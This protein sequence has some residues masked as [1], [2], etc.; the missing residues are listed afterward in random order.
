MFSFLKFYNFILLFNIFSLNLYKFL[1]IF[2]YKIKLIIFIKIF[3][4]N[5]IKKHNYALI[6]FNAWSFGYYSFFFFFDIKFFIKLLEEK[7]KINNYFN[8]YFDLLEKK[9]AKPSY[10]FLL[11]YVS[12]SYNIIKLNTIK[13]NIKAINTNYNLFNNKRNIYLDYFIIENN[14]SIFNDYFFY[15]VQIKFNKI[16]LF[17]IFIFRLSNYLTKEYKQYMGYFNMVHWVP[18]DPDLND[19]TKVKL[20]QLYD[21]ND[22]L[23]YI[24]FYDLHGF[25]YFLKVG[26]I[27]EHFLE[28]SRKVHF[29][30][31]ELLYIALHSTFV[32]K[33]TYFEYQV[34]GVL[35]RWHR[36]LWLNNKEIFSNIGYKT[37]NYYF[38]YIENL[39]YF[40]NFGTL[41]SIYLNF[42]FWMFNLQ[43]IN[44]YLKNYLYYALFKLNLIFYFIINLN[45]LKINYKIKYYNVIKIIIIFKIVQFYNLN[46]FKSLYKNISLLF[47]RKNFKLFFFFYSYIIRNFYRFFNISLLSVFFFFKYKYSFKKKYF[48]NINYYFYKNNNYIKKEYNIKVSN[49]YNIINKNLTLEFFDNK[50]I[51]NKLNLIQKEQFNNILYNIKLNYIANY[52]KHLNKLKNYLLFKSVEQNE[53]INKKDKLVSFFF[54][55]DFNL[56]KYLRLLKS[57]N[58]FINKKTKYKLLKIYLNNNELNLNRWLY[59]TKK[60]GFFKK[61]KEE[62]KQEK[63]K[64]FV[65]KDKNFW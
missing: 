43:F 44:Y 30:Y 25:F 4:G 33:P 54:I 2:F 47:I 21:F 11:A 41:I 23:L 16:S 14:R 27:T 26:F 19:I 15:S 42:Y 28:L 46:I 18:I 31:R 13:N 58:N 62:K 64:I 48:R 61:K 60:Q 36:L 50:D 55:E 57:N 22:I 49:K 9:K 35:N 65:F 45:F 20:Q 29:V 63:K 1:F 37:I 17:L 3:N 7:K 10:S 24:R 39:K 34:A 32:D 53:I 56:N 59:W 38:L 52:K 40:F 5:Y 6:P 51:Y 12:L 8:C